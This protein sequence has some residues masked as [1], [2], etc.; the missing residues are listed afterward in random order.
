MFDWKNLIAG[1]LT[2]VIAAGL[3]A[4]FAL[5]G[6]QIDEALFNTL[7]AAIVAF[8]MAQFLT[9][10]ANHLFVKLGYRGFLPDK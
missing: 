5:I 6:F 1:V 3:K 10:E 8:I 4:L 7:V 9:N 2:L